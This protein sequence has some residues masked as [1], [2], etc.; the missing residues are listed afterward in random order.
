MS[1][2]TKTYLDD[3]QMREKLI[4]GLWYVERELDILKDRLAAGR[5]L[6]SEGDPGWPLE[7]LSNILLHLMADYVDPDN[8]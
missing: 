8:W 1:T 5:P 2:T 6:A 4:N 7:R 3:E